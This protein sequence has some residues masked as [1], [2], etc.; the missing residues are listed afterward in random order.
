MSVLAAPRR[1]LLSGDYQF[2][3]LGSNDE[4]LGAERNRLVDAMSARKRYTFAKLLH[5]GSDNAVSNQLLD[6][7]GLTE[8]LGICCGR[9]DPLHPEPETLKLLR[10]RENTT[11]WVR[12]DRSRH[13]RVAIGRRVTVTPVGAKNLTAPNDPDAATTAAGAQPA[14]EPATAAVLLPQSFSCADI[15]PAD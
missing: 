13:I 14:F 3:K 11:T 2:A 8:M 15:P 12:T 10:H 6:A 9:G 7:L 1:I 4:T 5:H